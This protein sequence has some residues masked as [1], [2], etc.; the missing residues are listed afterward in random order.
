M[1]H[2]ALQHI[3]ETVSKSQMRKD[4]IEMFFL[5]SKFSTYNDSHFFEVCVPSNEVN[6]W[7]SREF[8]SVSN[9]RA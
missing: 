9:L 2:K 1:L 8:K 7:A 5:N 3:F 4:E 6:I